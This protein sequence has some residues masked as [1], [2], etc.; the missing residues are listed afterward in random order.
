MI[1]SFIN[2]YFDGKLYYYDLIF[3]NDGETLLRLGGVIFDQAPDETIFIER[4]TQIALDNLPDYE[5]I[6]VIF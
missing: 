4:A 1:A 6:Q 2:N 5:L 3:N